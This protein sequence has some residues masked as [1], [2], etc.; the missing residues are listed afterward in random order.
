MAA[1]RGRG[2][3]REGLWGLLVLALLCGLGRPLSAHAQE[4][5]TPEP[6]ATPAPSATASD[7]LRRD[8]TYFAIYYPPGQVATV[9]RYA[10]VVDSLYEYVAAIF[11]HG[12]TP[13]VP[14]RLYPDTESYA[15]VNPIA[16]FV[17]GVIAHADARRG[18]IGVAVDRVSRGGEEVLRDTVRHE[19]MHLVAHELSGERLPIGFQEGLAQYA[20]K[21]AP[22]LRRVVRSLQAAERQGR[23]LSWE[24]LNSHARFLSRMDVAYPQALSVVAFLMD[25]YGPGAFKRFLL[26]LGREEQS[27]RVALERVYGRDVADLEAEWREYLPS[28]FASRWEINLLRTLDLAEAKAR[29]AAG[30]YAAARPLFAEAS[31]LHADLGQPARQ[32]EADAYLGRIAMAL[33][34]QDLA[35]RGRARLAERD[36]AQAHTLLQEADARYAQAGDVHQ[37][38]ALA[39][40]LARAARGA[41][42]DEQLAAAQHLVATWRY[43]EGRSQA[44]EAAARYLGIGDTERYWQAHALETE[45]EESQRRLGLLL[46]GT[47]GLLLAGLVVRPRHAAAARPP[48]PAGEQEWAL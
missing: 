7:W 3:W 47:G 13:P 26:E 40:S 29:F 12:P 37:R 27:Y 6:R 25:R 43:G 45:A 14:M 34:A 38:T 32:A 28:Y 48:A 20:E 21:E 46:L 30:E 42:A 18:E 5:L 23:L 33:E 24:A 16:R 44:A 19:L 41:E 11:D 2:A 10:A 9:E 39:E 1:V 17:E 8:T 22:E 15:A 4:P 31:R 36:Y 35:T